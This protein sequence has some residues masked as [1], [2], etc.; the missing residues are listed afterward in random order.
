MPFNHTTTD[1]HDAEAPEHVAAILR[2][3]AQRYYESQSE[4][5]VVWGD[6][7]AGRCWPKLARILE[8]AAAAA[9]KI[10]V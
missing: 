5:Q 7:T 1:L 9:E 4:L 6:R 2:N 3:A 8:R 10:T